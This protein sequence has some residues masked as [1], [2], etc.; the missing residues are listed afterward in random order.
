MADPAA[1]DPSLLW[2]L[3]GVPASVIFYGR[4]YVQWIVSEIRRKSVMPVAFWYMS[5]T[6]SLML[7]VY[8]VATTSALGTLSHCFNISI[9]SRNLV[10]IWREKGRLSA[11]VNI[12]V[13]VFVAVVILVAVAVTA[14]T[15]WS[16]YD[17]A[18]EGPSEEMQ[19]TAFWLG[20]GVLGQALFAMRFL[21][22]W[23]ATERRKKS[24]IPTAF[25]WLSLVA[26]ALM[27]AS[28]TREREWVYAVGIAATSFIYA[29]N[30]W[31][32]YAHGNENDEAGAGEA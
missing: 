29:R 6:G 24:V 5:A 25:W 22:Q 7:L 10:H 2:Y 32:V 4:F 17:E 3:L 9:Y 16:V 19:K 12:G 1:A 21:V 8:G 15:W 28:F 30:L 13:H 18:T 11:T 26:S 31:L 23:I 20:V 27:C 14:G